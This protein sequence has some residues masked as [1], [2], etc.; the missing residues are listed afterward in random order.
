MKS[1]CLFA[2][3]APTARAW[4]LV[5]SGLLLALPSTSFAGDAPGPAM[6]AIRSKD[7]LGVAVSY[8]LSTPAVGQP[9]A[10]TLI[11][12]SS[13]QATPVT[14]TVRPDAG[15]ALSSPDIVPQVAQALQASQTFHLTVTPAREGLYYVHVFLRSGARAR[16]MA[17]AV[18]VGDVKAG[19]NKDMQIQSV[20]G[21]GSVI[22]VPA[23]Q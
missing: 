14:I 12:S 4:L 16:A 22:A 3:A 18:P 20:R 2:V 15:L 17:I 1:H 11:A 7:S 13:G 21:G 19:L 5:G 23:R 6:H 9:S 8:T 10:L